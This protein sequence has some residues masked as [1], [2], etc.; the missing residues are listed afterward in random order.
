MLT[1]GIE[2]WVPQVTQYMLKHR[3]GN[4]NFPCETDESLE[5]YNRVSIKNEIGLI[6]A[7]RQEILYRSLNMA[8]QSSPKRD[9]FF[10]NRKF[11]GFLQRMDSDVNMR[12]IS[13]A[14]EVFGGDDDP[15]EE[16]FENQSLLVGSRAK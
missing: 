3:I 1:E 16:N 2:H 14:E 10:E 7:D 12:S 11:T 5:Q 13:N 6:D 8:T 4:L 9:K 15:E